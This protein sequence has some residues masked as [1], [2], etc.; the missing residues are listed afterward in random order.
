M[1]RIPILCL[2]LCAAAKG[3]ARDAFVAPSGRDANDGTLNAPFRTVQKAVDTMAAGDVC[4]VRAGHYH[5]SVKLEGLRGTV[6][7]P[8]VIK[9]YQ[10]ETVVLD[11]TE[12]IT[13]SWQ[14]HKGK[15][16]KTTLTKDIWQLFV[17]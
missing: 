6:E 9:A 16:Y 11:G 3:Y 8:I 7:A 15:I 17:G 10:G 5:E 4:H 2:F 14:R 1:R 13:S 12:P